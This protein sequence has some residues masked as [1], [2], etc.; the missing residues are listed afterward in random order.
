MRD[1]VK[2]FTSVYMPKDSSVKHPILLSRTPYSR[3]PYGELKWKQWWN[4]YERAYFSEG[5]IMVIQ[6]VRGRWMSE[7]NF[8]DIRPLIPIKRHP[9]R[10]IE[11]YLWCDRVD[12]EQYSQQQWQW[13]CM[14][15]R[16]RVLL[17]DGRS[18]QSPGVESGEPAGT[19]DQLVYWWWFSSQRHFSRWMHL[20][21]YS[22][23][24]K[25]R[26]IPTTV[27]PKDFDYYTH[28]NY[29]FY[30]EAGSLKG[31]S[32][33]I[34]DDVPFWKTWWVTRTMMHGGRPGMRATPP[35]ICSR[36]CCG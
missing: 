26:P 7:G 28:D 18:E 8:E 20:S 31:L 3:A 33:R 22:S 35:K 6:D 5:Y 11:R 1:G 24:G 14:V 23:F 34:G 30:L 10:R 21:F 17:Y 4:G 13:G 16:T 19:G 12:G 15:F 2:L 9:N 32:S 29:K 27:G 36:P 25:P